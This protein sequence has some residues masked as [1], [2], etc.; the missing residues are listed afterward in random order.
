MTGCEI[1]DLYDP[2]IFYTAEASLIQCSVMFSDIQKLKLNLC[3]YCQAKGGQETLG[4]PPASGLS[5]VR[6][7]RRGRRLV[8][9]TGEPSLTQVPVRAGPKLCSLFMADW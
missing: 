7:W 6:G 1:S 5:G 8:R 3:A 2:T 9:P 4:P